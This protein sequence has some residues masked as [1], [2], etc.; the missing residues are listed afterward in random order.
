MHL[1]LFVATSLV[2]LALGATAG[3]QTQRGGVHGDSAIV[4]ALDEAY[5]AAVKANDVVGMDSILAPNFVLVVGRGTAFTK[6]VLLSEA[7]KRVVTYELQDDTLRAVRLY[8]TTAV[9]TALLR[10]KGMKSETRFD[11]RLWFS[12][13]YVKQPAGWRYVFG[14]ASLPLPSET[15][16]GE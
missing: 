4:A 3:A 13:V 12:D 16:S 15:A 6:A 14:Q 11:R 1:T 8:G 5:Q 9:V 2:A 10:V 7:R